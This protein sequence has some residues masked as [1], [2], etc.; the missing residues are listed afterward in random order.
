MC[1][2]KCKC[3]PEE[4]G[5]LNLTYKIGNVDLGTTRKEKVLRVTLNANIMVAEQLG[6]AE[7]KA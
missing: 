4:H 6:I 2:D 5:N 1:R 7:L 3:L